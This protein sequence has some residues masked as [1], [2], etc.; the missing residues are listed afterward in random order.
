MPTRRTFLKYLAG[1]GVGSVLSWDVLIP[2]TAITEP[3]TAPEQLV[4]DQKVQLLFVVVSDIHI[5]RWK[6]ENHFSALLSDNYSSKPDAMVVVGDLGDGLPRYYNILN[7]LLDKH[8]LEINY[9][10]YWTIGN[11]EYYSGFYKKGRWSPRTFPNQETDSSAID[12]FLTFAKRDKVYGDAWVKDYHFIFLGSE[13]SRMSRMS[14]RD[15][16]YLSDAQLNWLEDILQ[17][18][19]K[20]QKPIFVFLHQPFAYATLGGLQPGYVIQWQRLNDIL[21]QYPKVILFNGHTHYKIEH[22]TMISEADFS[23]V[24]SS[25]LACPIDRNHRLIKNSAPGF[26]VEVYDTKV[27]IKGREFLEQNWIGGAEITVHE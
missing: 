17:A 1:L 16:A 5:G 26:I 2:K 13:K 19:K 10:I 25:S 24:N 20:R 8:K 21:A 12:R 11:H 14:Y 3:I 9:P 22:R 23:I 7:N 27:V 15:L 4:K 18:D 6:A